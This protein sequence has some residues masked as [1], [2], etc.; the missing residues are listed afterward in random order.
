MV[1]HDALVT[2]TAVGRDSIDWPRLRASLDARAGEVASL[3]AA[4]NAD[5]RAVGLELFAF[6]RK[7]WLALRFDSLLLN[8]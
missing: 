6:G 1:P 8:P 7:P 4:P 3:R 2:V 5:A